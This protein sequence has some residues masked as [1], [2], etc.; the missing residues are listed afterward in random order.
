M[1]GMVVVIGIL[2]LVVGIVV[3]IRHTCTRHTCSDAVPDSLGW[4]DCL[5]VSLPISVYY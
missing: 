2:A 4:N 1:L 3:V 5:R